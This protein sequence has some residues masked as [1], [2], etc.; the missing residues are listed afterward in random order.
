MTTLINLS[1]RTILRV[2]GPEATSFLQSLVTCDLANA[3]HENGITT[4]AFGALLTPQGKIQFDFFIVPISY[5]NQAEGYFIDA[6]ISII[7]ALHKRLRLYKLRADVT[8]ELMGK[9]VQVFSSQ[10][11][12]LNTASDDT[13]ISMISM[14]DPRHDQLGIRLYTQAMDTLPGN[15]KP[16]TDETQPLDYMA[17]DTLCLS[18]G[19]PSIGLGVVPET[20]FPM[21]V[22]YDCLRGVSYSKGCF[23]GQEVVSRMKR[24]GN[25]RKRTLVIK[26]APESAKPGDT[27]IQDNASIGTLLIAQHSTALAVIRVDRYDQTL[28]ASVHD[29]QVMIERPAYLQGEQ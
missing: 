19:V 29:H 12:T 21:D 17:Y 13:M 23:I 27:I 24:K 3:S 22:N 1:N 14:I 25:V 18:L 8:L 10:D 28:P 15:K 16:E 4:G 26:N 9:D 20:I 7:E 2:T 6:H 11:H 5:N